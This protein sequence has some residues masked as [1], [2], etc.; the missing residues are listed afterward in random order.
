MC[1][2]FDSCRS[3]LFVSTTF[4][5]LSKLAMELLSNSLGV[6]LSMGD[7]VLCSKV[8]YKRLLVLCIH[9]LKVDLVVWFDIILSRDWLSRHYACIDC[10]NQMVNF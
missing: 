3:C 1:T 2:L 6:A 8:A 4:V 9:F 10:F 7:V 5:S